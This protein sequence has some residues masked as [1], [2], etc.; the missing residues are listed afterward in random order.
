MSKQSTA[1]AAIS[2]DMAGPFTRGRFTHSSEKSGRRHGG[3]L[4]QLNPA[5]G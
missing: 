4:S 2:L 1:S 5:A 3:M